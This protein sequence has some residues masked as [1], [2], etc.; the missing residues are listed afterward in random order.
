MRD[1][2][3]MAL[4]RKRSL[5]TDPRSKEHIFSQQIADLEYSLV[6]K[7]NMAAGERSRLTN[8]LR[9]IKNSMSALKSRERKRAKLFRMQGT[10]EELRDEV[11]RL[12]TENI[13]LRNVLMQNRRNKNI[14]TDGSWCYSWH[15]SSMFIPSSRRIFSEHMRQHNFPNELLQTDGTNSNRGFSDYLRPSPLHSCRSKH[16]QT[17][18]SSKAILSGRIFSEHL[19]QHDYP[20]ERPQ[21][22]GTNSEKAFSVS[23]QSALHYCQNN[24]GQNDD[25]SK[26]ISSAIS[27]K[28]FSEESPLH[29]YQHKQAQNDGRSKFIASSNSDRALSEHIK[30]SNPT[31]LGR[32]AS[33]E[34][35]GDFSDLLA[36]DDYD[37]DFLS[38]L[39]FL[40]DFNAKDSVPNKSIMRNGNSASPTSVHRLALGV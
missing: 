30:K 24:R 4:K 17:N 14:Q 34:S 27:D 13:K 37:N 15:G 11:K 22:D 21:T 25:G 29:F 35:N 20:N 23:R 10:V 19:R 32:S 18:G 1:F 26:S 39:D 5:K 33:C 31:D 7:R 38:D 2:A 28:T 40:D 3:G 12:E 6:I 9:R 36:L 8:K 16:P